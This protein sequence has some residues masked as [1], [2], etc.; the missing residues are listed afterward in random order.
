MS[1]NNYVTFS[2]TI[3]RPK[4]TNLVDTNGMV[5]KRT[6]FQ[7]SRTLPIH[8]IMECEE[9]DNVQHRVDYNRISPLQELITSLH[10]SVRHLNLPNGF[11]NFLRQ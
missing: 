2:T 6:I 5:S 10:E 1:T 9:V 8:M 7:F 3:A 11:M 4:V